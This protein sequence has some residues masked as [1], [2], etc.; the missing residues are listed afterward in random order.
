MKPL[1]L[2]NVCAALLAPCVAGTAACAADLPAAD[3]ASFALR[4]TSLKEL[5]FRSTVRQQFDYSCGSAAVATLLTYHFGHAVSEQA[6]FQQMYLHGDQQRIQRDGFS[7]L[8]IK[9]YL[10]SL[11][12]AADG[13]ELPLDKLAEAGFPAIV[14]VAERGY[15]HFVVV[16]GLAGGR[17]LLGDPAGGTRAMPRAQFEA[18]WQNGLLFVVHGGPGKPRFNA[19]ADWRAAPQAA[20]AGGIERDSLLRQTLPKLGDGNF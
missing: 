10:A 3:G 1:R 9:R 18:I 13:F 14:L 20:L 12:Y 2:A 17:V 5:R 16:K 19:A 4:I 8:D 11:G 15:H 7:L 6:A